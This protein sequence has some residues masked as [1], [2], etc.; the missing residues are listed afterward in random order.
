MNQGSPAQAGQT[1][2]LPP[3]SRRETLITRP[4]LEQMR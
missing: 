2:F 4:H 1:Y 3:F